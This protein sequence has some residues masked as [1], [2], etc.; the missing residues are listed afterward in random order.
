M[1]ARPKVAKIHRHG[2]TRIPTDKSTQVE[3]QARVSKTRDVG[4]PA[5]VIEFQM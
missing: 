5:F 4:Y 2:F 3:N 1:A